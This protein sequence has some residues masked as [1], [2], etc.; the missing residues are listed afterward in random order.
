MFKTKIAGVGSFL[1]EKVLSNFDLEK[2]IETSN[3]WIIQ[4]T[5]IERRHVIADG[6]GTSDM[7]VRAA[8]R[9]LEDAKLK[10][11]DID[12]IL[13]G[14][15]SGDFRMPATA[16]LVQHKLGAR[17][18]MSVDI[19]AACSGFIY[20]IHIADQFIKTGI[21]KNILVV[22]AENLTRLMNYKDRETCILFGDGA[23]AF[24]V[25][26]AEAHETNVILTTHAHAEG[27]HSELLW[28]EGGG[29]KA[30][31]IHGL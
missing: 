4:R 8:R 24:I 19:N 25:S 22:G 6:E 30:R 17:N 5:G 23:G 13:V 28:I 1:P 9:A 7:I 12:M 10:V 27:A 11:E 26:R 14:T 16:C 2:M 31:R 21:Y 20:G 29:T 3:E 18:V 15:L